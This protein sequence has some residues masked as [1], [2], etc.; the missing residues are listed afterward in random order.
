MDFD[1][2]FILKAIVIAIVEGITEFL[3]ISSTGHMILAG[4]FI[5]FE[6]SFE[7]IFEITIQ[8]GAILAIVVLF[9][10]KIF[11]SFKNL[12][13]G[14]S[15]FKLWTNIAVAF[16]PVGIAGLL[17]H[18]KVISSLM[19]PLPVALALLVGGIWMLFAEK[20]FRRD[21][22]ILHIEDVSYKQ[23]FMIGLFQV[24]AVAW[25]GF[26]RSASTII[27][28]W[29]VG[30]SA[31]TGAEFAFFLALPTIISAS[32]YAL[33]QTGFALNSKE[34]LAII[35]GFFVSFF[36]ALVVVEQFVNYI[37]HKSLKGFAIYRI[38]IAITIIFL[39]L[40]NVI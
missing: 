34:I 19:T 11:N 27:G 8:V 3:P 12:S 31:V 1:V 18:E 10:D 22:K 33:F 39:S 5:G 23:A 28:S 7:K 25:P 40:I 16:I 36:I 26:S 32:T 30:L 4:R 14:E 6:G 38:I 17:L 15:G 2:Y 37:K 9:K 29:I 21:D 20:K 24:I 13:P 35:V